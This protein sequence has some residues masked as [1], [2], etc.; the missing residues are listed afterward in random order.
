MVLRNL[1]KN[2]GHQYIECKDY[3]NTTVNDDDEDDEDKGFMEASTAS[4]TEPISERSVLYQLKS[5][6]SSFSLN[7]LQLPAK[8]NISQISTNGSHFIAISSDGV[9]YTWGEGEKG[10]LGHCGN[11]SWKQYPTRIESIRKFN[12]IG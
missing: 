4:L 2:K 8:I 9:V 7:P 3:D 1:G 10:Q 11:I 5:F 6:G 12:I